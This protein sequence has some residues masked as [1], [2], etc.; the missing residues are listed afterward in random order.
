MH[1]IQLSIDNPGA[2]QTGP[3]KFDVLD[4][5]TALL[6]AEINVVEG[7]AELWDGSRRLARLTR[8]GTPQTTFWQVG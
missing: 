3:L 7:W 2:D 4:E 6:V 8:H 5:A 1:R